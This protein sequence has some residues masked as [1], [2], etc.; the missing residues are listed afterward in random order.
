MWLADGLHMLHAMAMSASDPPDAVVLALLAYL[1]RHPQAADT[2]AGVARWWV[3][4]DC[5]YSLEQVR[6]ALDQLVEGGEL[7]RERLADGTDWYAGAA[8]GGRADRTL[9]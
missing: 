2:L 3:G 1:A 4:D 7:R 6:R 8:G 5:R 9:H